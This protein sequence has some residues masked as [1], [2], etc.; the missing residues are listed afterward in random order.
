MNTKQE[1]LLNKIVSFN[2]MDDTMDGYIDDF[3]KFYD[4]DKWCRGWFKTQI[5]DLI[6]KAKSLSK[7]SPIATLNGSD[8]KSSPKDCPNC[9]RLKSQLDHQ[10]K[11]SNKLEDKLYPHKDGE[12][13]L[14]AVRQSIV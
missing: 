3:V 8:K 4:T 11:Y 7:T 1:R 13:I 14:K 9:S 5:A 12:P 10:I 2:E 6:F